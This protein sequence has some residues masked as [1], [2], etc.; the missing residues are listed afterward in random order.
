VLAIS[1]TAFVVYA[2]AAPL[3][4]DVP[5]A[6]AVGIWKCPTPAVLTLTRS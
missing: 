2:F 4:T 5:A 3:V 6:G 1:C